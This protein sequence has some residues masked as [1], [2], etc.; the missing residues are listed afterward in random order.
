MPDVEL[1]SKE[2]LASGYHDIYLPHMSTLLDAEV[3]ATVL[4]N[5][6]FPVQ[7][8]AFAVV[9]CQLVRVKYKPHKNCLAVYDFTAKHIL[10]G[11]QQNFCITCRTYESQGATRRFDKAIKQHEGNLSDFPA[12]FH[13]PE[14][15]T[16]GWVFPCESKILSLPFI[17]HAHYLKHSILP[18]LVRS[19]WGKNWQIVSSSSSLMHYVPE[20]TCTVR[21]E[22]SI[23]DGSQKI[24]KTIFGK[25]YY[26]EA[27]ENTLRVMRNLHEASLKGL[28]P[29]SFPAPLFYDA[30][31]KLLWQEGL[32]GQTLRDAAASAESRPALL[33]QAAK[34]IAS[35]HHIPVD[36]RLPVINIA[37][38]LSTLINRMEVLSHVTP[39]DK[40]KLNRVILKLHQ[41]APLLKL[42]EMVTLHGD[43]HPQNLFLQNQTIAFIDL[44]SVVAGPA[45]HDI[46]SW[47]CGMLYWGA[48]QHRSLQAVLPELSV[49]VTN[50][51]QHAPFQIHEQTLSWFIAV[52]LINERIFRCVTRFKSGRL[53]IINELLDWAEQFAYEQQRI[54]T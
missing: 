20:H 13:V 21:V 48:M 34:A 24:D 45:C 6:L 51:N 42:T 44:D 26:N 15:E 43:V 41:T 18:K 7:P 52:A 23:T 5:Q 22:L 54:A 19:S 53:Q 14:L 8:E 10:S 11:K 33:P 49:F 31:L 50:Y 2:R 1:E 17:S 12:V 28:T 35:F 40:R 32:S 30:E 3:M 29:L 46:A 47:L 38:I 4:K 39:L 9:L 36:Q 37:D 16:I 25:C 27:G